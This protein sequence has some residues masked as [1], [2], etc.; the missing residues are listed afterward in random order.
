[1]PYLFLRWIIFALFLLMFCFFCL[2]LFLLYVGFSFF[3]GGFLSI[4]LSSSKPNA[5]VSF[6]D[7]NLSVDCRR[8]RWCCLCRTLFIFFGSISTKLGTEYHWVKEIHVCSNEG[9]CP[10][11][12]GDNLELLKKNWHFSKFFSETDWPEKLKLR[13][14]HP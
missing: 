11:Q 2:L 4:L 6:S 8:C 13:W 9:P 10:F 3:G 14:K 7:W 1:M 12:R 5:Q